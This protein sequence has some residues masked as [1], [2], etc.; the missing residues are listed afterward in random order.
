MAAMTTAITDIHDYTSC[1]KVGKIPVRNL[2]LL[3]L[4]A[5]DLFRQIEHGKFAIEDR[6]DDI[7]DLIAELLAHEVERRLMRNLSFGYQSSEAR[8]G[9]IRGHIDLLATERHQLLARGLIA[10]KFDDFTVNTPRNRFVRAA[11]DVIAYIVRNPELRHRCRIL[12]NKFEY[13][14]VSGEK[15]NRME[16][17]TDRFSRHDKDDQLMVTAAKLAFN[18]VLPTE[19]SGDQSLAIPEREITWVRRLYE[20]AIGGFYDVV[21][22]PKGWR[23]A[24]GRCLQ[25]SITGK[26]PGI[27]KILPSMRTDIILDNHSRGKRIV[28]DTKFTSLL[29]NGWYRDETIRNGYMYQIYAYLRSQENTSD[30]LA[31]H[32]TGLLIHPSVGETIDE[33]VVIQGHPIRFTTVD[34][35]AS[36]KIIRSQLIQLIEDNF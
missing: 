13:L 30:P 22:S 8:L 29:I 21:L 9:R 18:L 17:S 20:K 28:I 35:S 27:D 10:C 33:T 31:E 6:P 15:P 7:P 26:T 23:V 24:T 14:G 16:V 32:A 34:L 12:S 4:Y 2:W 19:I 25:W 1:G 3:M 36:T 5:S 11:L